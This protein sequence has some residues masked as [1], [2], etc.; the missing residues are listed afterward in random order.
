MQKEESDMIKKLN[1]VLCILIAL[2]IVGQ[3]YMICFEPYYLMTETTEEYPQKFQ[4]EG[5]LPYPHEISLFEMVW[6][7]FHSGAAII[8]KQAYG[9]WG[10]NLAQRIDDLGLYKDENG[11]YLTYENSEGETVQYISANDVF[12]KNSNFFVMG[13]VG[14]TVLG[15]IVAIMT[16]FT[17]KSTVQFAF[18]LCWVAVSVWGLYNSNP[19]IHNAGIVM[20]YALGTVLPTL[21]VLTIIGCVLTLLRAYPFVYTRYLSKKA[22]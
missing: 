2:I 13:I 16:I 14:I 10:D 12:E 8:G 7:K 11:E 5:L 17:R 9:G 21:Q 15:L 19:I 22:K 20:P 18:T 6:L 3:M 4:D 1:T